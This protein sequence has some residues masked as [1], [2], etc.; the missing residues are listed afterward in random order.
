MK[1]GSQRILLESAVSLV[2]FGL[3]PRAIEGRGADFSRRFS[4]G[5]TTRIQFFGAH[6]FTSNSLDSWGLPCAWSSPSNPTMLSS[7]VK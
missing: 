3:D 7:L 6:N 4:V 2:S 1:I 5:F